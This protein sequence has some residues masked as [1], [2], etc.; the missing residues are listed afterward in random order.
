MTKNQETRRQGGTFIP[1]CHEVGGRRAQANDLLDKICMPAER[2]VTARLS[3]STLSSG[4]MQPL[5][6]A[7]PQ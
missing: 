1:I 2:L 7:S 6:G 3:R 4:C 5:S